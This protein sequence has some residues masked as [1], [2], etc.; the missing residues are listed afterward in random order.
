L[1]NAS[2]DSEKNRLLDKNRD[3]AVWEGKVQTL[4]EENKMLHAK[5]DELQ[6]QARQADTHKATADKLTQ[7]LEAQKE[8]HAKSMDEQKADYEKKMAEVPEA[9]EKG[10]KKGKCGCTVM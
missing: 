3:A 2:L 7:D 8:T 4:T 5:L 10:K 6:K 1:H 9:G